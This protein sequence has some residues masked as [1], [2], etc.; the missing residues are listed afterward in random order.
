MGGDCETS[1]QN[2]QSRKPTGLFHVSSPWS[3]RINSPDAH[4]TRY[5]DGRRSHGADAVKTRSSTQ[6]PAG[7][8]AGYKYAEFRSSAEKIRGQGRK[9]SSSL[10]HPG[11]ASDLLGLQ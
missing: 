11:A 7:P 9:D 4:L 2:N 3:L 6:H 5:H 1:Q 8:G 10:A